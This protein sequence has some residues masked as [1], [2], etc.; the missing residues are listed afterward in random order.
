MTYGG[1]CNLDRTKALVKA[2]IPS[3]DV[4]SNAS[5][6]L[7]F[8]LLAADSDSFGTLFESLEKRKTE[9][10]I[11]NFGLSITTMEDVFLR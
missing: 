2:C 8:S 10:D 6:E 1:R 11:G 4:K 3:S 9:L 7:I 5:G